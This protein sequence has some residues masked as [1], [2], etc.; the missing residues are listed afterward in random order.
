MSTTE[1]LVIALLLALLFFAQRKYDS[2][3]EVLESTKKFFQNFGKK[4]SSEFLDMVDADLPP[5][6]KKEEGLFDPKKNPWDES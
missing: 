5:G 6:K 2:P 3:K 1:G 4:S